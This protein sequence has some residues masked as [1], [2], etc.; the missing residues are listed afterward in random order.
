MNQLLTDFNWLIR[1]DDHINWLTSGPVEDLEVV[2]NN[3]GMEATVYFIGSKR[4]EE[5]FVLKLWNKRVPNDAFDQYYL[6]EKLNRLG[7][8]VPKAYALGRNSQGEY[9]LLTNY[10]GTPLPYDRFVVEDMEAIANLLAQIHKSAT[11]SLERFIPSYD[12]VPYFFSHSLDAEHS[13]IADLLQDILQEITL[14][15]DSLIHGDY[16]LGNI[17]LADRQYT[18]IDWTNAQLGDRRYDFA[19]ANFLIR[20][21]NGEEGQQEFCSTYTEKISI[22]PKEL[23]LFD[24]IAALRWI[25]L[26]RIAPIPIHKHTLER[27]R[28]FVAEH[29]EMKAVVLEK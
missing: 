8:P 19:W 3:S 25:W 13:D 4:M 10:A 26:S 20:I 12:L 22:S 1:A 29:V 2:E 16:N 27:V 15:N 21:Y 14:T 18:V 9:A 24:M 7:I 23:Y 5:R 6:L 11:T 17:L 28:E